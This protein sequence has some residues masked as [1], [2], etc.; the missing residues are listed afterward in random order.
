MREPALISVPP[1]SRVPVLPIVGAGSLVACA[2]VLAA[3]ADSLVDLL[4]LT[5]AAAV[6]AWLVHP[7]HRWIGRRIGNGVSLVVLVLGLL[8]VGGVLGGFLL[9]DLDE[10][11]SGLS[12]RVR[13]AVHIRE[14]WSK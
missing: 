5:A 1:A 9:A 7:A 11:A 12:A 4:G 6:L 8:A 10:G 13:D 2:L 14:M 3:V